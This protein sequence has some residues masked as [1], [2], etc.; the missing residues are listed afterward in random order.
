MILN[1]KLKIF[2][3]KEKILRIIFFGKMQ[4]KRIKFLIK[5]KNSLKKHKIST[6]NQQYK[7]HKEKELIYLM[8]QLIIPKT[9]NFLIAILKA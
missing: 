7:E 6:K 4:K 9:I 5:L 2:K 3:N 1:I 8:D